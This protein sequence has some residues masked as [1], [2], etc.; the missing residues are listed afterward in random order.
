MSSD[1]PYLS[2]VR[3]W[4]ADL[5]R[6]HLPDGTVAGQPAWRI[7]PNLSD[8]VE[9]LTTVV[10]ITF[11]TID[12]GDGGQPLPPGQCRCEMV[13]E[14]APPKT[15]TDDAAD[16]AVVELIAALHHNQ[17]AWARA[18]KKR[19]DTGSIAWEIFVSVLCRVTDP[20]V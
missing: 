6:P 9:S 1:Q 18:E 14:V 11:R 19:N 7:I 16:D 5:V 3:N 13:V 4:V 20:E 15:D 17:V 2:N 12:H 8:T 10:Y